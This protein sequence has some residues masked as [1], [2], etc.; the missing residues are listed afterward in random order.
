[1]ALV[2]AEDRGVVGAEVGAVEAVERREEAH[3]QVIA[4]AEGGAARFDELFEESAGLAEAGAEVEEPA[5]LGPFEKDAVAAD[6]ARGRRCRA[7]C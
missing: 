5:V 6:F 3:A 1:V 4:Q 2:A 7:L